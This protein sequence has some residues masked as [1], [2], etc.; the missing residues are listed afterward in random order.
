MLIIL[1]VLGLDFRA[2]LKIMYE[3]NRPTQLTSQT[4]QLSYTHLMTY[5]KIYYF[6]LQFR[7]SIRTKPHRE[8][9]TTNN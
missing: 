7:V 1:P 4:Q 5:E 8:I 9:Y 6:M 3:F 2:A